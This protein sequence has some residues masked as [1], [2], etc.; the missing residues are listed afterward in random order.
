M[1]FFDVQEKF[2]TFEKDY[3]NAK[4]KTQ[5]MRSKADHAPSES[6]CGDGSP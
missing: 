2:N 5:G 6:R 3:S 1:G 4:I